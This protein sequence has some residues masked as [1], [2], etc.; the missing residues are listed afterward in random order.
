MTIYLPLF[1]GTDRTTSGHT[2]N[3]WQSWNS[4]NR[5]PDSTTTWYTTNDATWH[6]TGIQ[7]EVG[8]VATD[9]EHRSYGDELRRCQRYFIKDTRTRGN[10]GVSVVTSDLDSVAGVD[11]DFPTTMRAAPSITFLGTTYRNGGNSDSQVITD[12]GFTWG[13]KRTGA[14]GSPGTYEQIAAYIIDGYTAGSEL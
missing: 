3:Q 4:S 5:T 8:D 11:V 14:G 7:L 9:F 10:G 1:L 2:L 12:T 6:M 13:R